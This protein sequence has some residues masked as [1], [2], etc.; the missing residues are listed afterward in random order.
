MTTDVRTTIPS[1]R[2]AYGDLEWE[3]DAEG[4]IHDAT[5]EVAA[6]AAAMHVLAAEEPEAG[7]SQSVVPPD[8]EAPA[9]PSE[10]TPDTAPMEVPEP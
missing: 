10:P 2:M 1:A 6:A 8:S 4:V 5:P 9:D 7:G 3:T